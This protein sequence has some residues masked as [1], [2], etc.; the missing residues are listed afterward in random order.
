M[1]LENWPYERVLERYD[2]DTTLFYLDPPYVGLQLY[3]F[4][5]SDEDFRLL[6]G[7][8]EHIKGRFLLSINDCELSRN[9]FG[10]F[11]RLEVPIAYTAHRAVPTVQ[12]LLF[13]NYAWPVFV[14]GRSRT[15]TET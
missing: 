12:E 11:Q 10:R 6:A 14:R 8:L 3:R 2:R 5:F 7:R 15:S 13:S 4:N 9:I 1:Q